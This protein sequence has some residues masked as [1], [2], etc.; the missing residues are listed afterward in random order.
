MTIDVTRMA[1]QGV[2]PIEKAALHTDNAAHLYARRSSDEP[3]PAHIVSLLD[4]ENRPG[5]LRSL[6]SRP[7]DLGYWYFNAPACREAAEFFL[8]LAEDLEAAEGCS[9][10]A[11]EGGF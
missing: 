4:P 11:P 8:L 7:A 3:D 2:P 1:P 5:C 6:E 10:A 9:G